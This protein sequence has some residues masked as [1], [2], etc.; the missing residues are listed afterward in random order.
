MPMSA[1]QQALITCFKQAPL[2][3]GFHGQGVLQALGLQHSMFHEASW[4]MLMMGYG[5]KQ[6]QPTK[7]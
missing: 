2:S 1:A 6:S 4:A 3:H 5:V 7:R